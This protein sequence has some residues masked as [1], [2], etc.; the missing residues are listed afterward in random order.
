MS[1]GK[2]HTGTFFVLLMVLALVLAGCGGQQAPAPQAT[3]A[4]KPAASPAAAVTQP[5]AAPAATKAPAAPAATQAPAAAGGKFGGTLRIGSL[6]DPDTLNVLVSNSITSSWILQLLYPTMLTYNEKGE[7]VPYAATEFTTSPDGKTVTFKLRKDIKW[8]DGKPFTS[9]DVK[10]TA[11]AVM[12]ETIGFNATLLAGVE[13]I[14][15]PDDSTIVFKLKSPSAVF[16]PSIG[17]WLKVVPEHV[18]STVGSPKAYT[19]DK[20]VGAGPFKLTKYERGQYWELE[21]QGTHFT[22]PEG[23]PYLDKIQFRIFP[24]MNTMILSLKKGEIDAIANPVPP[25]SAR[26]LKTDPNINVMQT[27]SLG[28]SHLTFNLQRENAKA[29]TDKAVRQAVGIG[30]EQGSDPNHRAAGQRPAI[31][32]PWCRRCSATSTTRRPSPTSSTWKRPRRCSRMPDTRTRVE[33]A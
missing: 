2:K 6:T 20:P 33:C 21:P 30:G 22:A 14:E 13:S 12:K 10:Y 24:D 16:A 7:K 1:S 23:R 27:A 9:K 3:T 19:N 32:R 28:Y 29:L 17:Y 25:T 18:W 8:D 26:E 4:A 31:S 11:E 5:P 15:T